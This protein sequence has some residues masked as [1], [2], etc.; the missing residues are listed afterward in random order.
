MKKKYIF[1]SL[2]VIFTFCIFLIKNDPKKTEITD[3]ISEEIS[4]SNLIKNVKYISKDNNGNEYIVFADLGEIDLSD[5]NVI[6][7]TNV[8]SIIKLKN[9]NQINIKSDYGKY[10][11]LNQ[12]TIFNR[13]VEILYLDNKIT[14]DNLDFS[15]DR[16]SMFISKNVTYSNA[17]NELNANVI[18]MNIKTQDTKIYMYNSNS[19][20]KIKS[21]N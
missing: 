11:I 19:K 18:E 12:D 8:K 10:N 21:K 15:I 7:L 4:N 2:I 3:K 20:V 9:K 16:N 1:F 17:E 14:G 6:Y 13:N 5:T